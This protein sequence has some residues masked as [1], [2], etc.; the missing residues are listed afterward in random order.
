M[1]AGNTDHNSAYKPIWL[2]IHD[3][4]IKRS[5]FPRTWSYVT[6][7]HRWPV[8]SRQKGQWRGS[9]MFSLICAWN[10]RLSRHR[11]AV[12]FHVC[13]ISS[14]RLFFRLKNF[15]FQKIEVTFVSRSPWDFSGTLRNNILFIV[16]PRGDRASRQFLEPDTY[17]THPIGILKTKVLGVTLSRGWFH[18]RGLYMIVWMFEYYF[19]LNHIL[20]RNNSNSGINR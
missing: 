13:D 3:D 8:D 16:S 12:I 4:V 17:G 19:R 11:D 18:G 20:F 14:C 5:H 1:N 9:L 10:K 7:I 15:S 6:G 2:E